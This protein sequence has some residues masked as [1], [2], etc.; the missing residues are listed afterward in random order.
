MHYCRYPASEPL[1]QVYD[2][3]DLPS[4][5]LAR[6]VEQVGEEAELPTVSQESLRRP[7][8]NPRLMAK[9]LIFGYATGRSPRG[10]SN[11][12]AG[13]TSPFST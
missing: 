6:L 9:V 11:A 4:Y 12:C 10:N 13:R 3:H 1:L 8:F 5:R 7:A 2:P